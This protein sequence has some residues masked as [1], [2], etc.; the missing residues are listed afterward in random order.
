MIEYTKKAR[1]EALVSHSK[2]Q[3][4]TILVICSGEKELTKNYPVILTAESTKTTTLVF[5]SLILET[6]SL[7]L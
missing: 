6:E 5:A 7:F 4:C 3:C 2:T 1:G